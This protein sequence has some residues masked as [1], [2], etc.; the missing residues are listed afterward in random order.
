M[1]DA[2]WSGPWSWALDRL[3]RNIPDD[4]TYTT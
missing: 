4:A 1:R 2:A 3:D